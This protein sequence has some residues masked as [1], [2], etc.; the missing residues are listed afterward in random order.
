MGVLVPEGCVAV[1]AAGR[2]LTAMAVRICGAS[3]EVRAGRAN[4]LLAPSTLWRRDDT[5]LIKD[6]MSTIFAR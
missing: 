4:E 6:T 3:Q 1:K 5:I 2:S